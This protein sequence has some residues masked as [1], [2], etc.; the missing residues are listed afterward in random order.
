MKRR[1]SKA[2]TA[3]VPKAP[4]LL[5]VGELARRTGLT[6]QALHSYVQLGL[7][8]P[9]ASSK[10]GHRLFDD[11]AEDRVKLIRKLSASGYS[12]QDIREIFMRSR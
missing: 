9:A 8:E 7:L 11:E 3:E 2:E 12:L 4:V 6:R 1:Q 10:G 5:K